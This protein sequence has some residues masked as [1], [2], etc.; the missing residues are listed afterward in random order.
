ML[1]R[2]RAVLI[3]PGRLFQPRVDVG[4][5]GDGV[6][7]SAASGTS[8]QVVIGR[9]TAK[10]PILFGGGQA[11]LYVYVGNDPIN[12]I[13][14]SGLN[15]WDDLWDYVEDAMGGARD[16]GKNYDDMVDANTI[17]ADKYFHCKANCE[18]ASRGP[19]G[20]DVSELISEV[21][22]PTDEYLK[23][24]DRA[25]AIRVAQQTT[26]GETAERTGMNLARM[27][28]PVFAQTGLT[29]CTRS[30]ECVGK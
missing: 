5:V 28:A 15:G 6:S 29:S 30:Q 4:V 13:D 12:R 17:G 19:G 7:L 26:M 1:F 22:E 23:G 10:D 8:D 21:R 20:K 9:W 18:A 11:N 27:C 16:F 14:P 24:D 2:S 3:L 25:F